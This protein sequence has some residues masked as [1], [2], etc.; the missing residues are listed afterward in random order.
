MHR[1]AGHYQHDGQCDGLCE[2]MLHVCTYQALP[3][4]TRFVHVTAAQIRLVWFLLPA[5]YQLLPNITGPAF[6]VNPGHRKALPTGLP[7][8]A[9]ADMWGYNGLGTVIDCG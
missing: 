5:D 1:Q 3:T 9:R 2:W 6:W 7:A 8:R 4:V